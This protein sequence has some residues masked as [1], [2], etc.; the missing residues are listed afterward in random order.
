MSIF[1]DIFG[2]AKAAVTTVVNSIEDIPAEWSNQVASLKA[3]ASEFGQLFQQLLGMDPGPGSPYKS[4]YDAIMGRGTTIKQQISNVT[5]GID[6]IL[7]AARGAFSLSGM[8]MGGLGV[9]PLIPIA[10][11]VGAIALLVGWLTDAY[12]L[13]AKLAA[14]KAAGATAQQTADIV[15]GGRSSSFFPSLPGNPTSF[16]GTATWL[17]VIGVGMMVF[18]P[19]IKNAIAKRGR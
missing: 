6:G 17:L 7:N 4:E 8:N 3:K 5:S 12:N 16:M 10:V 2:S 19:M 9:I 14:A 1:D 18:V 13:R 15:N 11:I